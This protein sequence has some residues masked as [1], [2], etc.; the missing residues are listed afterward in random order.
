M[1]INHWLVVTGTYIGNVIIPT[2]EDIFFRGIE[3]THQ[4]VI[5]TIDDDSH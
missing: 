2:D 4:P 1:V 5:S 3:A